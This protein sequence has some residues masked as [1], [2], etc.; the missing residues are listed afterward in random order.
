MKEDVSNYHK[1]VDNVLL[2]NPDPQSQHYQRADDRFNKDF[3]A[4]DKEARAQQRADKQMKYE[5]RRLASYDREMQRWE[6]EEKLNTEIGK[7][8]NIK[9]NKY[10]I[11]KKTAHSGGYNP[12]NGEYDSN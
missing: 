12:I 4:A 11:G 10:Q 7:N 9:Q 3:A 2:H 5:K 1:Y 8:N 6:K